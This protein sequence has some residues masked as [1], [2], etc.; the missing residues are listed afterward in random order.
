MGPL[1]HWVVLG[2]PGG[3]KLCVGSLSFGSFWAA[4]SGVFTICGTTSWEDDGPLGI[5]FGL[6]CAVYESCIQL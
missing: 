4:P 3:Q 1:G 2:G 6:T 5:D